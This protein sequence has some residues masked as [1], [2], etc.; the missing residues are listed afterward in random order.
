[1]PIVKKFVEACDGKIE[2]VSKG[3]NK[4]KTVVLT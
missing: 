4:G 2:V 3:E 1:M